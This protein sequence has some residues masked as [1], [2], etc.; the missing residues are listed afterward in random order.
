MVSNNLQPNTVRVPWL[1]R[2]K[3]EVGTL[4][5]TGRNAIGLPYLQGQIRNRSGRQLSLQLVARVLNEQQQ[6]VF[7]GTPGILGTFVLEPHQQRSF[8]ISLSDVSG[9]PRQDRERLWITRSSVE[10]S[11]E[12]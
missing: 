10:L 6:A 4:Q 7:S 3:L 12:G 5:L 1:L 2:S 9:M 8:R 11:I